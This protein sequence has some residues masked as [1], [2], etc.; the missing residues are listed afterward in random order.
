[1]CVGRLCPEKGHLILLEA[2]RRLVEQGDD[3]ELTIIGDGPLRTHLE[4]FSARAK[5]ESRVRFMGWQSTSSVRECLGVSRGLILASFAEGLPIVI[6][7]ALA[8]A[9]PVITSCIAGIP[10]LVEHRKN[11]WLIP[12]GSVDCLVAS[13]KEA[14][15][16]PID[17][18]SSMG[19]SGREMV[20]RLH[21]AS[22]E[23]DKLATLFRRG[24]GA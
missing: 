16:T 19:L 15:H 5:L 24:N 10:E 17:Q 9:R 4:E 13:I 3:I 21:N 18:L 11:G 20:S 23:A 12:A 1:M 2:V 7:E 8:M 22:M 6:M 14:I